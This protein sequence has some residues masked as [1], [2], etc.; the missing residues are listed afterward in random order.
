LHNAPDRYLEHVKQTGA[1]RGLFAMVYL[2]FFVSNLYLQILNV[3][4]I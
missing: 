1:L 4:A 2:Y 3:F